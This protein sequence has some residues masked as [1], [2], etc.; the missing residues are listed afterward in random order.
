MLVLESEEAPEL[1]EITI[2][3][4][5]GRCKSSIRNL[6][7]EGNRIYLPAPPTGLHILK[8]AMRN[9]KVKIMKYRG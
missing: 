2:F 3:S 6:Q 8:L 5:D 7:A 4:P 9:G 1:E